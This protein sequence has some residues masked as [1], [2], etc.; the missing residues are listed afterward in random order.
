[1]LDKKIIAIAGITVLIIIGAVY[2]FL[3]KTVGGPT[4]ETDLVQTTQTQNVFDPLSDQ[5]KTYGI[6]LGVFEDLTKAPN[7]FS[8]LV[9][10]M[11]KG[12][13]SNYV[14]FPQEY[15]LQPEFYPSFNEAT[16]AYWVNP[17]LTH[18]GAAGYGFYP[19]YQEISIPQ[20]KSMTAA[21]FV[22]AGFGVQNYQGLKI[23][24]KN[25]YPGISVSIIEPQLLLGY[26]Y[27]KFSNDWAK[28]V[29]LVISV[30][31]TVET[32]DYEINF[33]VESFV[34]PDSNTPRV[35][36]GGGGSTDISATVLLKVLKPV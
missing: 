26:S 2:L 32:G 6:P 9:E 35:F 19:A 13:Y 11:H 18:Y 31:D 17:S 1:M 30:G 29:L 12:N 23:M 33:F 4:Q 5:R 15:F 21:F 10:K 8:I 36:P 20:G 16:R 22:H 14:F 34:P 25:N 24:P 27:P 28:K 3:P 7:D